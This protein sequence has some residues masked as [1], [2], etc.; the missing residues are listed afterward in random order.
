VAALLNAGVR[1]VVAEITN[2]IGM[3]LAL[4][5]PGRFRM[6]SP[7]REKERINYEKAR[8]VTLTRP[9]YLGV[10]A[11]TQRQY[12]AVMGS[13]PSYFSPAGEGKGAVAGL[14]TADFPVENVTW[15]DAQVFLKRLN[16]TPEERETGLEYRLP[17]EA[18]WEYAC[19]G[20]ASTPFHAGAS[21]SSTQANFNG[22]LP[23]GRAE[24]GPYLVRTCA[25][26]SYLPNAFGLFDV[27]G[28]VLEWCQD[29]FGEYEGERATDPQGPT[30]GS[31]R[32]F[33]GGS[34]NGYGAYCRAAHR[35]GGV[36][37]GRN[38][39][40]GFRVAAVPAE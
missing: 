2:S 4:I 21:L 40:L 20:G 14:D 26:G 35:N 3:R 10:F 27:Q 33:R 13:N 28:N 15:E 31:I 23:Y 17:T 8:E 11:V 37:S 19:R 36:P 16:E 12:E 7:P 22:G 6:G 24:K 29:W 32:V 5:P 25:V 38:T 18:E 30:E 39:Y 1:P 9:F 34:W